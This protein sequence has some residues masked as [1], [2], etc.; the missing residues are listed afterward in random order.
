MVNNSICRNVSRKA[1]KERRE[2]ENSGD[3]SWLL[4]AFAGMFRG[5][6]A[7]MRLRGEIGG[8]MVAQIQCLIVNGFAA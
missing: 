8:Q 5:S 7:A 3:C 4:C 6:F 1:A 2:K